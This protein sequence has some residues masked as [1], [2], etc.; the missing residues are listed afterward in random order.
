[1]YKLMF[2]GRSQRNL[3]CFFLGM[4]LSCFLLWG[5]LLLSGSVR[6]WKVLEREIRLAKADLERL[7][8]MRK[9]IARKKRMIARAQRFIKDAV[10]LGLTP[11][12]WDQYDVEINGPVSFL[13]LREILM[14]TAPGNNYYFEPLVFYLAKHPPEEKTS[15]DSAKVREPE[16]ASMSNKLEKGDIFLRLKG[17][18]L[19]R[20]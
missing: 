16:P 4:I 11:D 9:R 3:L 18:F 5:C 17:N 1:M 15:P 7:R 10:S 19:V 6:N 20:K 2:V 8:I 12:R 13:Q 14:Q